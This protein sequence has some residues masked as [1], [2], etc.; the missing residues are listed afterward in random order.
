MTIRPIARA[1]L[2]AELRPLAASGGVTPAAVQVA[3]NRLRERWE[4]PPV[5]GRRVDPVPIAL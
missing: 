4:S 5:V 2:V 3:F 1:E